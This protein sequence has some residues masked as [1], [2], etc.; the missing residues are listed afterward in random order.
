MEIV[1]LNIFSV[2][3]VFT[4]AIISPGPNFIMVVN[5]ALADSRRAG[6]YTALGVATGSGLFALAGMLG[7]ILVINSLP[8]FAIFAPLVGGVY[9]VWLGYKMIR[10]KRRDSS[11]GDFVPAVA[12]DI[13]HPVAAYR[14]GLL[15]NL[16]NPKAWA[17]Y[18]SLFTLV[19]I[20]ETPFWAKVL[21][22]LFMFIISFAWY[23]TVAL[24]ITDIR[25][26]PLFLRVQHL[27][28]ALLGILLIGL[29]GRL[30]V[31]AL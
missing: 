4:L 12:T 30:L 8:Y 13:L 20:P 31:T 1:W 19:M 14:A 21:L 10:S 28:Q 9:L 15:T 11:S 17:F 7:L 26:R 25:I 3:F 29:G 22:N 6:F 27:V 18:L 2:L 5:T 23:A 24:L 16:A